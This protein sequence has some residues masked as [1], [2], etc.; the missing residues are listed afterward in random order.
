MKS[1]EKNKSRCP[2]HPDIFSVPTKRNSKRL[3]N[4]ILN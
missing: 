2:K 1:K 3:R 4:K